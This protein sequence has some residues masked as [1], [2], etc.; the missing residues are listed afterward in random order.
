MSND[1]SRRS[2]I[3]KTA[4]GTLGLSYAL[5]ASSYGNIIGANDRINVCFMGL[6][7]RVSAFYPSLDKQ[8]NA[9][10]SYLC[11]PKQSQVGKALNN[12][13]SYIDYVPKQEQDIR[14][15]L[16]DKDVDAVFVA[17]PDHWHAPA[18]VMALDAGKHVYV[19]KP[20]AHNPNE[21]EIMVARQKATRNMVQMGNQQ[22]SSAHTI[23]II[24]DIHA[25]RIGT[26]YKAVAFYSNGR[27]EVPLQKKQVPPA[28]LNWELFQGPAPR[29]DYT[30]DTWNYNWHWHGWD[31]GTAETGNNAV[32]EL[33]IARW[34]LQV[35]YPK[36]SVVRASK[37]HFL[38][39][40]WEMYDTMYASFLFDDGKEIVWDGK[41]R[42]S[43]KTYGAGRG[44]IIYGSEGSVWVDRSYYELYDRNG[45]L[46]EKSEETNEGGTALGG[47]GSTSTQHVNN[48]YE[49]IR[50]KETLNAPIHDGAI[51]NHMA[52]LANIG[53]RVNKPLTID[54]ATGRVSNNPEAMKMW[55]R[56][57]EPGWEMKL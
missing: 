38:N 37:N 30:H 4:A 28:D 19:E 13:K 42:N 3:K 53:Y 9:Q 27:G 32:H 23:K 29:R 17:P 48:F 14:R 46:L 50:G 36:E 16:E 31:Y 24:K 44:T 49:A 33:D 8:Y 34:A 2:F 22:R 57:Y 21:A 18:T 43:L 47:G 15:I 5:S 45:T 10:L 41:S 35:K 55:I 52:L 7:R 54:S 12:L 11:D 6:G 1:Q 56:T 20:C 25:G 39:D 51:S 40:G 26:P